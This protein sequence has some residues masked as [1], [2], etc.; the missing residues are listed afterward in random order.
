MI[1]AERKPSTLAELAAAANP[2]QGIPCP[3]CRCRRWWV[4]T[5]RGKG[6]QIFRLRECRGCGHKIRTAERF[7]ASRDS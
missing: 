2:A 7:V 5:N 1:M 6:D 3:E 4:T